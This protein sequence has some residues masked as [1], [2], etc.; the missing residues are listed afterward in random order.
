MR[1]W[2]A[3]TVRIRAAREK[4]RRNSGR[5]RLFR[6]EAHGDASSWRARLCQT[7]FR[8]VAGRDSRFLARAW[9]GLPVGEWPGCFPEM[10]PRIHVSRARWR[11]ATVDD[12]A[13]W[14]W[15][16]ATPRAEPTSQPV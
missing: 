11:P 9:P 14:S 2:H 12:F 13:G 1:L 7:R 4:V 15:P 3:R 5:G 6:P 10:G 8:L 16:A